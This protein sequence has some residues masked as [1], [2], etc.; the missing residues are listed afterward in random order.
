MNCTVIF[1]DHHKTAIEQYAKEIDIVEH[2]RFV[3]CSSI[4]KSGATLAWDYWSRLFQEAGFSKPPMLDYIQDYDLWTF[5]LPSSREVNAVAQSRERTFENWDELM[6]TSLADIPRL[7]LLGE[8]IRNAKL[9]DIRNA[10]ETSLMWQTIGGYVVPTLNAPPAWAS[11]AGHMLLE[12]HANVAFVATY[13]D[14]RG[15]RVYSLRSTN[16]REDVSQ[17]AKEKG[18]GGH[19]NAAGLTMKYW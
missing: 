6:S 16:E 9:Q 17:I 3:D 12:L 2:P 15:A 4:E 10:I 13:Y 14:K 18:G 19:R 7:H 11:E 8:A 5:K 1:L